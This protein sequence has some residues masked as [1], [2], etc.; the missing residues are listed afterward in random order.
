M[1]GD[2]PRRHGRV[3]SHPTAH[4]RNASQHVVPAFVIPSIPT[5]ETFE[6]APYVVADVI[7]GGG[8]VKV[9]GLNKWRRGVKKLILALRGAGASESLS[10]SSSIR[11]N[12]IRSIDRSYYTNTSNLWMDSHT[13]RGSRWDYI[14]SMYNMQIYQPSQHRV[15]SDQP[16]GARQGLGLLLKG[17]AMKT[18]VQGIPNLAHAKG[19]FF[20]GYWTIVVVFGMSKLN[21]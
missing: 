16:V 14:E 18:G 15:P 8:T 6:K 7:E 3:T 17:M 1:D 11:T 9:S 12:T 20:K 21:K 2:R 19:K 5:T 10:T 13:R 4:P